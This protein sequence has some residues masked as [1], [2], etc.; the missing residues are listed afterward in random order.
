MRSFP[1][2]I[3]LT[4]SCAFLMGASC[5]NGSRGESAAPATNEAAPSASRI[6]QLDGIDLS[7]LTTA[8][9]RTWVA[10]VNDLLSPCGEP[11]SVARCAKDNT[12][13]ACM[14]AARYMTRLVAEG[15][16]RSE[17]D[18]RFNARFGRDTAKTIELQGAPVRGALMAPITVVEFS[19][20]ECPFCGSAAP[21]VERALA[22]FEGRVRL[23]FKQYPLDQHPRAM[24][25]ALAAVAA[26][27]QNKF[28][29][30]HDLLFSHQDALE[31]DD[32]VGYARQ[33]G[34]DVARFQVDM[35]SEETR[36]HVDADKAEGRRLGITGTPSIFVNG[37]PFQDSPRALEAY[38]R[39]E[40]DR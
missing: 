23:V 33:L 37:R 32:L 35:A 28:W 13:G 36:A 17:I 6:E 12:C 15:F 4:A 7:E 2:A 19:D 25:A 11:V 31:D 20:F 8:E 27:K 34:L 22:S 40:L 30:M 3:I 29:E 38:L 39:E 21:L 10:V 9:K 5:S 14:P 1:L 18:A 16:E 26:G 24:P